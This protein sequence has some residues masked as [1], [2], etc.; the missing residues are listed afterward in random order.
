LNTLHLKPRP[1]KRWQAAIDATPLFELDA[2][3][4]YDFGQVEIDQVQICEMGAKEVEGEIR[5]KSAGGFSLS[6]SDQGREDVVI[7]GEVSA[8]DNTDTTDVDDVEVDVKL[9]E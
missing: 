9:K 2:L 4:E 7:T 1:K 8:S 6:T 5:Y 3:R